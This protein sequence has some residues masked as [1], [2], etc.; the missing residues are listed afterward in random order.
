MLDIKIT[1]STTKRLHYLR[2]PSL[3]WVPWFVGFLLGIMGANRVHTFEHAW[4]I[5]WC[6]WLVGCLSKKTHMHATLHHFILNCWSQLPQATTKQKVLVGKNYDR[7]HLSL[8]T[9]P[10]KVVNFV[11]PEEEKQIPKRG[12]P[13]SAVRVRANLLLHRSITF[14]KAFWNKGRGGHQGWKW[15]G[16][17]PD[18]SAILALDQTILYEDL[19]SAVP[20]FFFLFRGIKYDFQFF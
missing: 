5:F 2:N 19:W 15:A 14:L 10:K 17:S 6:R 18:S 7:P 4:T 12:N 3:I 9:I 20:S 13:L 16:I 8:L 1:R 11:L